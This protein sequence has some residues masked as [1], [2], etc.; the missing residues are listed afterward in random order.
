MK[1]HKR[2][3]EMRQGN[4]RNAGGDDKNIKLDDIVT[5]PAGD[6]ILYYNT[7]GSHSYV[8]WNAPPPSDPFNYGIT[9][10][11]TNEQ[12]KNDFK[13]ISGRVEEQNVI[14]QLTKLGNDEMRSTSFTLKEEAA[15]RVYAIGE[16]SYSYKQMADYG[17]IINTKTREKIWN[18]DA[19]RTEHA[20]GAEKNRLIDEVITLPKG[21]YTV[22]FQTDGSHSYDGWNESPPADVEHW[23]ITIYGEGDQFNM[24][25]VEKNVAPR[26]PDMISQIVQVGNNANKTQQF[27]LDK[28]THIKIYAIGEGQNRE[29]YDYGWIENA[30]THD[31]VWEM[32][33]SMTFHAGGGKK[34]RSVSTTIILDKG[35][36]ILH[37]ESDDSHSYNHWNVDPPDDPMM[38]G[39]TLT[40]IK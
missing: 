20:G 6:F 12:K 25:N 27:K 28:T 22:F 40:E 26:Q 7:D 9:M 17:W 13:L 15:I 31:V 3:W 16:R 18:M 1:N 19:D 11:I 21:T 10:M 4:V 35:S 39:I 5:F 14:A 8:D 24:K 36:Y 2:I 32:T 29:M 37:Y 30:S 33:Y 38:W 34:N 23:G